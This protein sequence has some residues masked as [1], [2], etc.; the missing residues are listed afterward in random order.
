MSRGSYVG[1]SSTCIRL[2]PDSF[3]DDRR[4]ASLVVTRLALS[5]LE[6]LYHPVDAPLEVGYLDLNLLRAHRAEA[7]LHAAK[8]ENLIHELV[9]LRA[10]FL[11]VEDLTK[12]LSCLAT[13]RLVRRVGICHS[14]AR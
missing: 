3:H 10:A 5:L 12:L 8:I 1:S 2:G 13:L 11:R 9:E 6:Q 14:Q 7:P 4:T